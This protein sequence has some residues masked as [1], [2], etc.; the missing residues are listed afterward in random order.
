MKQAFKLVNAKNKFDSLF[1]SSH[2]FDE[3]WQKKQA[4]RLAIVACKSEGLLF[5]FKEKGPFRRMNA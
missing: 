1:S 4:L 3:F 2:F 5:K